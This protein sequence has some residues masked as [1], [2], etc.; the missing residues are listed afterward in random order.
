MS[1]TSFIYPA[2]PRG[3][4]IVNAHT[5]RAPTVYLVTSFDFGGSS[6]VKVHVVTD[7][8]PTAETVYASVMEV[9]NTEN[10]R[11]DE[12]SPCKMLV[13]LTHVPLN[14]P[15]LGSNALTLYWGDDKVT[16]VN[17]ND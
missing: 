14:A 10:A 12:D 9:C 8:L 17:N 7:D 5:P 4:Q 13:E 15:L 11:A 1:A 6:Y 16:R 2:S 3:D